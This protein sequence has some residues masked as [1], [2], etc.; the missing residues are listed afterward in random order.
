[1]ALAQAHFNDSVLFFSPRLML[2]FRRN[3]V[4]GDNLVAD[5]PSST[6]DKALYHPV[7]TIVGVIDSAGDAQAAIDALCSYGFPEDVV[8]VVCGVAGA[9]Q[10]EVEPHGLPLLKRLIQVVQSMTENPVTLTARYAAAVENGHLC[11]RVRVDTEEQREAA[12]RI[13]K[14]HG[15]HYITYHGMN[16]S[17]VLDE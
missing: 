13:L 7:S 9:R 6:D 4:Q 1:M 14:E 12:R 11:V 16:S 5:A 2:D 3:A 8:A 17:T 15:G 10:L